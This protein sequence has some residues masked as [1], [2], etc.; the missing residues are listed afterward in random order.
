MNNL[1]D[2]IMNL[3]F[4]YGEDDF[5]FTGT[6]NKK[7]FECKKN[8]KE[9]N[10]SHKSFIESGIRFEESISNGL[11]VSFN[12]LESIAKYNKP[13]LLSIGFENGMEWDHF[14][15]EEAV[16]NNSVTFINFVNNSDLFWL[17]ENA[18]L[19]AAENGNLEL[20]KMMYDREMGIPDERF[21]L[22]IEKNNDLE[23]LGWFNNIKKSERYL[24]YIM[25]L[26]DNL[27]GIKKLW[28]N[29]YEINMNLLSYC[30]TYGSINCFKFFIGNGLIPGKK[31]LLFSEQMYR[32]TIVN[33]IF[34]LLEFEDISKF[35]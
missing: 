6:I 9:Y 8:N 32:H 20:C 4:S 17:A 13:E 33:Y 18:F 12:V 5:L 26:N 30:C 1:P 21:L 11:N 24:S 16:S 15:I 35:Y 28:E 29:G 14:C 22:C 31:E 27:E 34:E 10:T 2:D 7:T 3:I 25:V 19:S 23:M